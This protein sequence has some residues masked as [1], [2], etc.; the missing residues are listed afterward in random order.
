MEK[1]AG[2]LIILD[3]KYILLG[4]PTGSAWETKLTF[5]K[6]HLKLN[7]TALDAAIRETKEEFGINIPLDL[8]DKTEHIVYYEDKKGY[9][10][11]IVKY[12][13]VNINLNDWYNIMGKN[14]NSKNELIIPKNM[15]QQ[16][17]IDW[18]GFLSKEEAQDKIFWRFNDVL[19]HVVDKNV[20]FTVLTEEEIEAD[21][22]SAY[23]YLL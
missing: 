1:S 21:R 9:T 3:N 16:S 2:L 18:A 22:S 23:S 7:E 13:I 20:T 5:S 8:I 14:L 19:N 10:Y 6:G 17:E 15:L 11:K 4:H 12:F